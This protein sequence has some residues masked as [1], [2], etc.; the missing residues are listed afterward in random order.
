MTEKLKRTNREKRSWHPSPLAFNELL[1]F[2]GRVFCSHLLGHPTCPDRTENAFIDEM[3]TE[4]NSKRQ[5]EI[6]LNSFV[7]Q[8]SEMR[9]YCESDGVIRG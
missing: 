5:H 7:C 3:A 1:S 6:A 4:H 9:T 8:G 2:N